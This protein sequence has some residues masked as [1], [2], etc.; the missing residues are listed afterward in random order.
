MQNVLFVAQRWCGYDESNKI[1][2][3]SD[4]YHNYYSSLNSTGL[5]DYKIFE[6]DYEQRIGNNVD[7]SIINLCNTYKFDII[8]FIS[9]FESLCKFADSTWDYL[10]NKLSIPIV[11]CHGDTYDLT[12]H[13]VYVFNHYKYA[14]LVVHHD[15]DLYIEDGLNS[16]PPRLFFPI[17]QD[18]GI[19]FDSNIERDTEIIFPGSLGQY[20][21]RNE[22]LTYLTN[23]NLSIKH[24][25]G[26]NPA[27]YLSPAQYAL[28]HMRAKCSIFLSHN[29]KQDYIHG[30]FIES[31]LCG[32]CTF[33]N[34]TRILPKYYDSDSFVEYEDMYDLA[35]K[36]I[37]YLD[38]KEEAKIIANKGIISMKKYSVYNFYSTIFS[39]I[40][41]K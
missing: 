27:D 10:K 31:M 26:R 8:I 39:I 37:Y 11:F 13:P 22:L 7:K 35:D 1:S 34:K 6:W 18:S 30:H 16:N 3:L 21:T 23:M 33:A 28:E 40:G 25:G 24:V 9:Y 4:A 12:E 15:T 5:A 36:L 14:D 20:Q 29:Y 32:C 2:W 38:N 17:P 41:D 19:F